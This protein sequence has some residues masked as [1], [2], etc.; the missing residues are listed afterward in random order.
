MK[1]VYG[2]SIQGKTYKGNKNCFW[3]TGT[4]NTK[5]EA[6]EAAKKLKQKKIMI[7]KYREND[8]YYALENEIIEIKD[9]T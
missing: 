5:E 4:F 7:S 6:I 2:L 8:R 9:P 1:Y 3:N